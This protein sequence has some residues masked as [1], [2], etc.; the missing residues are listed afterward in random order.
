MGSR[1]DLIDF[2]PLLV[3]LPLVA[4]VAAIIWRNGVAP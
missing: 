3:I 2:A 4:L 1:S